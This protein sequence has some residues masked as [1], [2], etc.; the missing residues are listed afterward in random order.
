M[1]KLCRGLNMYEY[2]KQMWGGG[3]TERQSEQVTVTENG[4]S[5]WER[6]RKRKEMKETESEREKDN[7]CKAK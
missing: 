6:A 4:W 5:K 3:Q 2:W 7:I 1:E